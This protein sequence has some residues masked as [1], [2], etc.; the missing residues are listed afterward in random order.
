MGRPNFFEH[1]HPPTIPVREARFTY[2][3]GRGGVPPLLFLV[4]IV[5]GVPLMFV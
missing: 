4:L 3:F 5:T 2:T 1:L